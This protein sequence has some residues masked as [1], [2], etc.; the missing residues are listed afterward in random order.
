MKIPE[1]LL[2]QFLTSNFTLK[3]TSTGEIRINSPF[4]QDKKYHLYI[5]PKKGVF[6]DFKTGEKGK[7]EKLISD[8]LDIPISNVVTYLIKEYGSSINLR[9]TQEEPEKKEIKL[10]LPQGLKFFNEGSLSIIGKKA[11]S[12]LERRNISKEKIMELGYIYNDESEYHN[13]IFIPF[14]ENNELVY[15]ITRDFT[16]KSKMRYRNPHGIDTKEFVFNLDNLKETV[17][18]CEGVFDALSIDSPSSTCMLSADLGKRQALK[19]L[20]TVPKNIIFVPDNDATGHRTLQ[21]NIA[22]L[23]LY[24]PSSIDLN[25]YVYQL[26]ND[27]KDLNEL[28]VK[29]GKNKISIDECEVYNPNKIKILSPSSRSF[30]I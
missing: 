14:Y 5:E 30:S 16:E 1:R 28:R 2:L 6:N 4:T 12:Y 21:K 20:D 26:P 22:I 17:L 3:K 8:Y 7:I 15:F 23:K 11:Y 18:I 27:V 9:E 10:E 25:I 19:I 24:K 29:T 13:S